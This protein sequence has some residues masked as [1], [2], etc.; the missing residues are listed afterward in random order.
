MGLGLSEYSNMSKRVAETKK[1]KEHI[2]KR[3]TGRSHIRETK[4]EEIIW[5][6]IGCGWPVREGWKKKGFYFPHDTRV[7]KKLEGGMA[8]PGVK[9]QYGGSPSR[10]E[11]LKRGGKAL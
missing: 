10:M 3:L 5:T 4:G 11:S 7:K 1:R 2:T 6:K 8:P 9:E